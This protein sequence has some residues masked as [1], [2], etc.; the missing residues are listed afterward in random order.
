[1][2]VIG[3]TTIELELDPPGFQVNPIADGAV[4]VSVAFTPGQVMVGDADIVTDGP[5]STVMVCRALFV[6]EPLDPITVYCVVTVG[7][8]D[9]TCP[10]T[11]GLVGYH[12]KLM[13]PS[14]TSVTGVPAQTVGEVA[15]NVLTVGLPE[16][17]TCTVAVP[18]Q[19]VG[20]EPVTV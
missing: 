19:P 8:S 1:M 2:V 5:G 17:F 7:V 18:E 15:G 13:A 20:F 11:S 14:P 16:M 9:T 10:V 12:E 3:L 6:H 4:A